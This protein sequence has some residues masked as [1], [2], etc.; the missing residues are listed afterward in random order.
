MPQTFGIVHNKEWYLDFLIFLSFFVSFFIWRS[1]YPVVWDDTNIVKVAYLDGPSKD[2]FLSATAFTD[3]TGSGYRPLAEIWTHFNKKASGWADNNTIPHHLIILIVGCI[4][5]LLA[6]VFRRTSKIFVDNTFFSFI[7]I[8]LYMFSTPVTQSNWI[9]LAG[10]PSLIPFLTCIILLRYFTL[11]GDLTKRN[12]IFFLFM[13]LVSILYREFMVTIPAIL[14]LMEFSQHKRLTKILGFSFVAVIICLT[15]TA[16]SRMLFELSSLLLRDILNFELGAIDWESGLSLPFKPS[17][18]LGS[19]GDQVGSSLEFRHDVSRHFLSILSP[20]LL[21]IVF[22]GFF[23]LTICGTVCK[24]V[25]FNRFPFISV[26]NLSLITGCA[27]LLGLF[28]F[29]LNSAVGVP[30][31]FFHL[32]IITVFLITYLI[33]VRLL[34]WMFVFL[35]PF[36]FLYTERVHLAYVCLPLVITVVTLYY[37][38]FCALNEMPRLPKG[39]L[40]SILSLGLI[41]GVLDSLS[42]P[43]ATAKVMS[44]IT[45]GMRKVAGTIAKT[46]KGNKIELVSNVIHADDLRLFFSDNKGFVPSEKIRIS[47]TIRAGH[48]GSI[49]VIADR[50]ALAN[51][52]IKNGLNGSTYLLDV[53]HERLP[54]KKRYHSHKFVSDCNI[55]TRS[56]GEIHETLVDYRFIDPL[57]YFDNRTF[58][59]F[60]GPPDLQ[61]DFY[62]G[63]SPKLFHGRVHATYNLYKVFEIANKASDSFD[64]EQTIFYDERGLEV[65]SEGNTYKIKFGTGEALKNTTRTC[66]FKVVESDNLGQLIGYAEKFIKLENGIFVNHDPNFTNNLKLSR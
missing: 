25:S 28:F 19:A 21:I 46:E 62:Y 27:T 49:N 11:K 9:L 43:F 6:V 65:V 22:I 15:P 7:A 55:E 39:V 54:F 5:G 17:F 47:L 26:E 66:S 34:V 24:T 4:I 45:D 35:F 61:D 23:I 37:K 13:F 40:G 31:W 2:Y 59:A 32:G 44:G 51:I 50:E 10:I 38:C 60:L 63:P 36:Y 52:S 1:G 42:T 16:F 8:I 64:F 12:M 48:D 30:I 56:T 33:D 20:L 57:R 41:I 53:W 58:Y 18:L 29:S 14:V 3:L